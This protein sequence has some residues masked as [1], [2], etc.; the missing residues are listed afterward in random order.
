M[1][2]AVKFYSDIDNPGGATPEYPAVIVEIDDSV[3]EMPGYTIMT[4]AQL[5]A[6]KA[7]YQ[8]AYDAWKESS[9]KPGLLTSLKDRID[10]KTD[11]LIAAGFTYADKPFKL[12]LE[13]QMSYKGAY[14]LRAY[15]TFPYTIKGVGENY[16]E[17]AD[18]AAFTQFILAAFT[19][20]QTVIQT[21]WGIKDSLD[22]LTYAQLLAWTDPRGEL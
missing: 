21:G 16:L 2:Y 17:L 14:D 7:Q 9:L 22:A 12:D 1:K 19:Y 3:V 20:L 10:L 8:S 6:R 15:L 4:Q 18:E 5:D 13:H 11:S